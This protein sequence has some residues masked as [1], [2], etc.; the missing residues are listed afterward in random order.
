MAS[1][2]VNLLW[3]GGWDSTFRLLQLLLIEKRDVQP[4][5]A[6]DASRYSMN[7]ELDT[8]RTI[9]AMVR[10][11]LESDV[12]LYP[13]KFY[14]TS[15]FPEI[16]EI[17]ERYASLASRLHIARQYYWLALIAENQQWGSVELCTVKGDSR[18]LQHAIFDD[19]ESENPTLKDSWEAELFKYWS[20]PL[21]TTKKPEM[22]IIA[23]EHGFLDILVKRWFC[24]RPIRG[25]CCGACR[26]CEI[27]QR[28]K[29]T[30]GVM[31]IHP[32]EMAARNLIRKLRR[33]LA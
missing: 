7:R 5:Y 3:T 11:R 22:R 12:T 23:E 27:A 8:I 1:N 14:L 30:D 16:Q 4:I 24:L 33:T 10:Q 32:S 28:E 29:A 15:D 9:S 13:T 17:K 31:F 26:P 25:K 6:M 20:F 21:L 18:D 2:S 19:I